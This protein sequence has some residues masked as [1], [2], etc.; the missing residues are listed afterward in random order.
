[1]YPQMEM[2]IHKNIHVFCRNSIISKSFDTKFAK[3]VYFTSDRTEVMIT[4]N[5]L[6]TNDETSTAR[7]TKGR[8]IWSTV[9]LPTPKIRLTMMKGKDTTSLQG[10]ELLL[11]TESLTMISMIESVT[12]QPQVGMNA[13]KVIIGVTM[14]DIIIP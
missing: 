12:L 11:C 7:T 2:Y 14:I 5:P 3:L 1:M 9:K 8:C 10:K 13:A 4:I 6:T